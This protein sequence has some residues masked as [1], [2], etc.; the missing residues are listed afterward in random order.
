MSAAT[1]RAIV[2][3]L[4]GLAD[5]AIEMARDAYLDN[6]RPDTS[7]QVEDALREIKLALKGYG[8]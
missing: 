8:S 1:E 4:E 5:V 3:I 7:C 2:A 6:P